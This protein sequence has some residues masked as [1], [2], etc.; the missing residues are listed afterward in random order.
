MRDNDPTEDK[1]LGPTPADVPL[2]QLPTVELTD[3]QLQH[4][5]QVAKA[6]NESYGRING[7][8][9]CGD[10]TSKA[11]HTTGVFGELVYA[12]QYDA[13]IDNSVYPRG[14]DG[15]DFTSGPL[16]IDVKTTGT[17]IDRPALIVPTDPAPTA[18]LFFLVHWLGEGVGRIIGFA[19]HA[20]VVD[21]TAIPK[22]GDDLNYVVDQDEL[23]TPPDLNEDPSDEPSNQSPTS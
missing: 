1:P 6:R 12:T 15:H 18:D 9:V 8:R 4:A 10:Q 23:W 22:P 7:G 16:T 14:D 2:E 20:T 17:H 3:E 21:R 11:V 5:R 13:Q 19:T